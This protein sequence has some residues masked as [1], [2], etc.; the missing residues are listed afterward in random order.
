MLD[1]CK[2]FQPKPENIDEP[3]KVLHLIWDQLPQNSINKAILS[4]AKRL[5]VCVKAGGGHFEH[6]LNWTTCHI[7]VYIYSNSQ[8][9]LT[10]KITSC[11]WLF[12]A[13]LNYGIEYLYSHNF[14]ENW[15]NFLNFRIVAG[16]LPYKPRH[17]S[18]KIK[19]SC[20]E[21]AFC[22]VGYFNLSHPVDYIDSPFLDWF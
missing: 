11:C 1:R 6:T 9:F 8:C 17:L 15:N 18:I 3:K 2:S 10:M 7:L 5:R 20:R 19:Q 13:E 21:I 14:G 16:S 4:F 12:R 22:P